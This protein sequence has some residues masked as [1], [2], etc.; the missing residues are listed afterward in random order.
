MVLPSLLIQINNRYDIDEIT[1]TMLQT[2]ASS[3]CWWLSLYSILVG[4]KS[5][6]FLFGTKL[7]KLS[8][9]PFLFTFARL[10][11]EISARGSGLPR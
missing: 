7:S 2:I 4:Q 9:Q 8:G 1:S 10:S 3:T 5:A 11:G 6:G